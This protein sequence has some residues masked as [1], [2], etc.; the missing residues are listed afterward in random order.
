MPCLF[1]I[2]LSAPPN[3]LR[4]KTVIETLN[5]L[6][7]DYYFKIVDQLLEEDMSSVLMIFDQIIRQ[8]FSRIYS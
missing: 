6:D 4:Y 2:G 3:E 1:L 5:I 7:Y 8:G